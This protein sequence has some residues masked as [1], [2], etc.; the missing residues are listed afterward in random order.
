MKKN[1][2]DSGK[3][4]IDHGRVCLLIMRWGRCNIPILHIK[5]WKLSFWRILTIFGKGI[6]EGR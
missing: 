2:K 4:D 3:K 1:N 5:S 6:L